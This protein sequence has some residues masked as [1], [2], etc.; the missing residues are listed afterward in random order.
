MN[1]DPIDDAKKSLNS[2][3]SVKSNLPDIPSYPRTSNSP[4]VPSRLVVILPNQDV[5][6]VKLSR[7]LRNMAIQQGARMLLITL[8]KNEDEEMKAR[9]TLATLSSLIR[10]ARVKV[11]HQAVWSRGWREATKSI[12]QPGDM[13]VCPAEITV[14]KWPFDREF[15][16]EVLQRTY[17]TPVLLLH[18]FFHDMHR[19]WIP[20]FKVIS[21]WLIAFII[22]ASF[23][24]LE[25]EVNLII[26]GGIAQIFTI[27][28]VVVEAGAL[29]FWSSIAG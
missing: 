12:V 29:W 10:E 21:F 24:K 19:N 16:G 4:K 13:F 8:V 25:F 17:T 9:R 7:A 2:E 6:E 3:I 23:F 27:L 15:L 20:I 28:L 22:I 14:W 11:E 26:H 5:D 18:G 1:F